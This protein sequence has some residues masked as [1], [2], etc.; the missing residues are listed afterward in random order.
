MKRIYCF[1]FVL[2]IIV[3]MILHTTISFAGKK[4]KVPELSMMDIQQV[5]LQSEIDTYKTQLQALMSKRE[6]HVRAAQT[7]EHR[8]LKTQAVLDYLKQQMQKLKMVI[9]EEA[10]EKNR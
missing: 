6:A 3:G 2:N 10:D 1:I 4:T 7:I 8:M 9:V 5:Q